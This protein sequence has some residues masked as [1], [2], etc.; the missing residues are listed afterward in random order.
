MGMELTI[1]KQRL[2]IND[3]LMKEWDE[4]HVEDI[5]T[6]KLIVSTQMLAVY[7][8][9]SMKPA[10][11]S[12]KDELNGKVL[13]AIDGSVGSGWTVKAY[14]KMWVKL[15][16]S[17]SPRGSNYIETPSPFNTSKCGLVNIRNDDQ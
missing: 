14:K 10:I 8:S 17:K 12:T 3:E 16:T 2:N 11:V 6:K 5:E 13:K 9:E 7:N 4:I 1:V 15:H